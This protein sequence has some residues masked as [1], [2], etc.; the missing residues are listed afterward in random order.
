MKKQLFLILLIMMS[1]T[2][3]SHAHGGNQYEHKDIFQE[4]KKG[5][6]AAIIGVHFGTTH[7]DTRIKTIDAVNSLLKQEFKVHKA[8]FFEAYTSRIII[9]RLNDRGTKKEN[10]EQLLN[11]LAKEGYTHIIIQPTTIING[12]EMES[13]AKNVAQL[14]HLFKDIRLGSPLLYSPEDYENVIQV[15]TKGKG[16]TKSYVLVGHGTYDPT[17]AQYAMLDYM[18]KAKGYSNFVV[19]TIEGYPSFDDAVNQLKQIG[20]KEIVLIPFMF[21]AGEH[22]KNDIAEDWKEAL[23][24]EGYRVEA[25]LEGLGEIQEIQQLYLDKAKFSIH[26]KKR[27]IL[28]KKKVYE[29]TGEVME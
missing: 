16:R 20:N 9:K 21:V 11:K 24:K 1:I 6:K 28:D 12:L 8:D 5:D 18:L 19:G 22:A 2:T 3:N 23:E 4:M 29:V 10:P 27:E 15:I 25:K 7:E 13:L 17:T 26:H 14:K